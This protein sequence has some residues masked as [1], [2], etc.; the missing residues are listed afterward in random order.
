MSNLDDILKLF[1]LFENLH[2][3]IVLLYSWSSA[4]IRKTDFKI[5]LCWWTLG[6]EDTVGS[7][8]NSLMLKW[9]NVILETVILEDLLGYFHVL[10]YLNLCFR[11]NKVK[12]VFDALF[13]SV[14]HPY[15][16]WP[17]TSCS[18]HFLWCL[19]QTF[20]ALPNFARWNT[21]LLFCYECMF[22]AQ[23]CPTLCPWTVACQAP[24]S[25]GLSR[26]EYWSGLPC[27]SLGDLPD[28]GIEPRC[29]A[30]QA[31]SLPFELPGKPLL[32]WVTHLEILERQY[33]NQRNERLIVGILYIT[34]K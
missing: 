16:A 10:N 26:Q 21:I 28:P 15:P 2:A 31:N 1:C 20:S 24:L 12:S 11:F 4:K 23:L 6:L 14:L 25:M 18:C 30:L 17:E 8:L 5:N 32:L 13:S 29:P 34:Q 22:V 33:L 27:P 7:E 9:R 19:L 3:Q